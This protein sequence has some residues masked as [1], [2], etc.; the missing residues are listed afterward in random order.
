MSAPDLTATLVACQSPDPALRTAA[1]SALSNAERNNLAEFFV[2]LANELASEGK[3]VT[4]RQLAG[5]HFKNLLV[6]KDDALQVEKHDKWKAI[7]PEVRSVIKSTILGAIR[8][9]VAVARHTAAQASSEIATVELPYKEWPEFLSVMMEN[10]TGGGIDD[11]IKISSL[12]CL[13]FTCE[14]IALTMGTSPDT[15]EISPEVTDLML[16][17]IVDGIRSD[18]PDPIRFAAARALGNSLSFTRKNMENPAERDMILKTICDATQSADSGVRAAAYECIIQIAFQYY[19]KLQAYMQTLFQ[20]TFATI[21]NDE[22]KVALQAIEFWSTLAEEEM[23][24][25]DVA[26]ELAEAGQTPPPESACV[27]Y[28][29]AALEHLVPLLT[30]T[31][32]KQDEEVELDD[33]QWNLSMSG[34]TCLQLVANTVED[35]IVPRI[36]PFVQQNIQSENWRYREAATMAFSSIL[37]GPSDDAIGPYVN[38][39]IPF[40]LAALSDT[41]DLVK[42]TTAWTIGRICDLHVRSIPE[43]IFPTLVNGLAGKLLNETPRVSS[44]A[45][46]GIHNLAAAFQNDSAAATSG[47]N[48]LSRECIFFN[49]IF[50][51]FPYT[52]EFLISDF[53]PPPPHPPRLLQP[54]WPTSSRLCSRWWTGT[55]PRNRIFASLRLRRSASSS[56]TPRRTLSTFCCNCS[57]SSSAASP[58][59]STCP[60]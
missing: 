24:L 21:R 56:R 32:T 38:Q 5:L 36:M 12:E 7:A 58:N 23:E 57:P 50:S 37:E 30:E 53:I 45:C 46:F 31:L 51:R 48:A 13:G 28:V 29:N 54:T 10:V 2:A 47:T 43:D 52:G 27:G 59:P 19:D 42:D 22:E 26:A 4:V 3:D 16:T 55:M 9:P 17:T 20:L 18:R 6:A 8:S 60:L 14:R 25:N 11:G 33:D 41:N 1:E 35:A 44:Q 34:A 39:S 49:Y 15:P 40:L